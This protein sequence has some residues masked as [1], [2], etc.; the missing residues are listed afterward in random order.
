MPRLELLSC[1]LLSQLVKSVISALA[2]EVSI[3]NVICWTDSEISYYWITQVHK[4]WRTWIENRVNKI[5]EIIP[6]NTWRHI[7]G[8]CN[9]AD[10]ATREMCPRKLVDNNLWWHGPDFLQVL[11]CQWPEIPPISAISNNLE[12]KTSKP[13]A[14]HTTQILLNPNNNLC[15]DISTLIDIER[16]S[17]LEKLLRVTAYVLRFI[18][19]MKRILHPEDDENDDEITT[20]EINYFSCV[21][22]NLA[23]ERN[24]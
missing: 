2:D 17:S 13:G 14:R 10:L 21:T 1:L 7:P 23:K 22:I 11:G 6:P 24:P 4:E 12:L 8:L 5:R 20:A 3:Q 9:P 15:T 18:R 19:K 16:Y